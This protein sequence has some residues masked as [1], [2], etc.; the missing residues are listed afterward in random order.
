M[1]LALFAAAAAVQAAYWLLL[2]RGVRRVRRY[3]E[4][5]DDPPPGSLPPISVVVA[6]RDEAD[7]LPDLLGA[8]AA[9]THPDFEAVVVDDAS[10]DATPHLVG[11]RAESDPRFRLVR[12]ADLPDRGPAP[13]PRKKRALTA[14]IAA[15][16]HGRLAFTDADCAPPPTWLSALAAW[17]ATDPE[18]VLVGYGPYR[19]RPGV[20]NAFVRYET[21]VTALLTAGAVGL[22]RPYMAVGRNFSYPRAL[23]ERLGGF[24][25]QAQSLSGDDD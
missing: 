5:R 20:L 21:L 4:G 23:F 15:A 2:L 10:E 9:Q 16:S 8:L 7:R 14:G 6:A 12:A 3:A 1:L 24:A 22:G 17:A 19:R 11:E 13:L 18:A 25:H